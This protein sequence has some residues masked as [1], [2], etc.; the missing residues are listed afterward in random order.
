MISNANAVFQKAESGDFSVGI[1]ELRVHGK[2]FIKGMQTRFKTGTHSVYKQLRTAKKQYEKDK[3]EC[4]AV[5]V[6]LHHKVEVLINNMTGFIDDVDSWI[7][8]NCTEKLAK[9]RESVVEIDAKVS[10]HLAEFKAWKDAKSGAVKDAKKLTMSHGREINKLMKKFDR[11]KLPVIWKNKLREIGA[12]ALVAADD[13]NA[14]KYVPSMNLGDG[15][16][17]DWATEPAV[18]LKDATGVGA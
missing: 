3:T 2:N 12:A 1:L 9:L 13:E 8:K 10:E 5:L 7:T 6:E 15:E 18:F 4:P 16:F 14:V 17:K 11:T